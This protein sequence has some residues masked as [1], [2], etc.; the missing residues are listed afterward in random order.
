MQKAA[1]KGANNRLSAHK[2]ASSLL[3]RITNL[4]LSCM[5]IG[6][7]NFYEVLSKIRGPEAVAEWRQLQEVMRPLAKAAVLMPP[8]AFRWGQCSC[9][10]S[11]Q[12]HSVV[13]VSFSVTPSYS[14]SLMCAPLGCC[15]QV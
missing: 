9:L 11:M 7:D 6:N 1:S 3:L 8:V 15:M 10:G 13:R 12:Q 14:S 5:Q 4:L 2:P